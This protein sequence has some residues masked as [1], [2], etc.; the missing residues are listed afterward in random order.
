MVQLEFDFLK[1]S[2][3][4]QKLSSYDWTKIAPN[5][6]VKTTYTKRW[7]TQVEPA[8]CSYLG[9]KPILEHHSKEVIEY[10]AVR[11]LPVFVS[12]DGL[13]LNFPFHFDKIEKVDKNDNENL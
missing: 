6:W 1:N 2:V 10:W 9:D 8:L 4:D 12:P 13:Y 3:V 11:L 5:Q 7:T